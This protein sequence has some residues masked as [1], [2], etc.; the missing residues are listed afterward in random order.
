[1]RQYFPKQNW[2]VSRSQHFQI[3][4][5]SSLRVRVYSHMLGTA[6]IGTWFNS[7]PIR[8]ANI[9]LAIIWLS[10]A[11]NTFIQY[12]KVFSLRDEGEGTL[13]LGF[14]MS[15]LWFTGLYGHCCQLLSPNDVIKYCDGHLNPADSIQIRPTG[16]LDGTGV[17]H[18]TNTTLFVRGKIGQNTVPKVL[19]K[20]L[21]L[22][23]STIT[24]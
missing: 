9:S 3:T 18:Y 2:I 7:T 6:N 12:K 4:Q 11:Y 10:L 20:I 23:E 1:M 8:W 15:C 16:W 14:I 21:L 22:I 24:I 13:V 19:I 5:K 17:L